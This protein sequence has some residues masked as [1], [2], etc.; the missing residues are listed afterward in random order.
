[1]NY[2]HIII[3]Y[4][5]DDQ[6]FNINDSIVLRSPVII[7]P[8]DTRRNAVFCVILNGIRETDGLGSG[9]PGSIQHRTL[10]MLF[11]T[12]AVIITLIVTIVNNIW[13]KIIKKF[14]HGSVQHV[15]G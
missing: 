10:W 5:N 14:R 6:Q 15:Q 9:G 7:V 13:Q 12:H 2:L 11:F 3:H 1:M 4:R 8:T